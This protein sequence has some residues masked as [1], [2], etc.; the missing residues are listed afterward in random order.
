MKTSLPP[1]VSVSEHALFQ[2]VNRKLAKNERAPLQDA[3]QLV[4]L[5]LLRARHVSQHDRR[6]KLPPIIDSKADVEAFA[7]K[8]GVLQAHEEVK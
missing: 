1:K 6:Q 3:R 7:R 4:S 8:I 5:G 2:R